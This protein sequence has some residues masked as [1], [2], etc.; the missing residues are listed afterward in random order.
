MSKG[1]PTFF[2]DTLS[3]IST[4]DTPSPIDTRKMAEVQKET[5]LQDLLKRLK[6]TS[7]KALNPP[8]SKIQIRIHLQVALT[9]CASQF[10]KIVFNQFTI[11]PP[12]KTSDA[13]LLG[14]RFVGPP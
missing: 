1:E 6:G 11:F 3:R 12:G 9:I 13:K 2:A 5:R 10:R 14:A 8:S 4:I 7:P